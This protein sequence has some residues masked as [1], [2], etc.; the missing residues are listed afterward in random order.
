MS[1]TITQHLLAEGEAL[2]LV[3]GLEHGLNRCQFLQG[4]G[5]HGADLVAL[6]GQ[7]GHILGYLE[8]GPAGDELGG[9]ARN[10]GV[11]PG[12]GRIGTG[13]GP[14]AE[15]VLLQ[16]DLLLGVDE[17]SLAPLHLL[18]HPAIHILMGD[19]GLLCSADHAVVKM[20]GQDQVVD[21]PGHVDPAVH[22]CRGIAGTYAQCRLARGIGGLDHA[23]APGGQNGGYPGVLH[24][25]PGGFDRGVPDPLDAI[26]RSARLDGSVADDPGR[27]HRAALCVGVESEDD[28]ATGLQGQQRFEDGCRGGVGHRGHAGYNSHR[29]GHL[30]DAVHVV[31]ADDAH[32]ALPGQVIGHMLAGKDVLGGLVLHQAAPGLLHGHLRQGQVLVQGRDRGLGHDPIHLFLVELLKG[33]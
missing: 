15:H 23:G 13:M 25:G 9:L 32:G 11:E 6:G 4:Q 22:I 17:V 21:G 31:L 5:F 24:E 30:D 10:L 8:A 12:S 33:T 2:L 14:H 26:A 18:D 27:L 19:D 28:G 16:L 3:A 20:L 7:N 29:L 1:G